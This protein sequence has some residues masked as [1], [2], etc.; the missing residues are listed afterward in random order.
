MYETL[1]STNVTLNVHVSDLPELSVA[2]HIT[3]VVPRLRVDPD[4]G[5]HVTSGDGSI[6]SVAVGAFQVTGFVN[7]RMSRGQS[8]NGFSISV[9]FN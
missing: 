4:E 8:I 6:S 2:V 1:P 9:K 3:V 7:T 5:T